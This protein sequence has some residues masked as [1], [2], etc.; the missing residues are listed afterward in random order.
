M[1]RIPSFQNRVALAA[2]LLLSLGAQSG[3]A[4][5]ETYKIDPTHSSIIFKIRHFFTPIPGRFPNF[6]GIIKLD[7][8][9][10]SNNYV[11]ATIKVAAIDTNDKKRDGHLQSEDFFQADK[12]PEIVYKSTRW[13][14]IEKNRY[15]VT[16]DLTMLDTTQSIVM[17]VRLNGSGD[18]GRGKFLTG[19][20]ASTS[21]DRTD[22]GI[23]YMQGILGTEVQI[24]ITVEAVK[25]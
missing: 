12:Y 6:A 7:R 5:I 24:E 1:K 20:E 16:G 2:F 25:Q 22:Y 9:D 23:S 17:D 13:E 18:N 21:L 4:E 3:F 15:R 11:E 19:W 14:S 10:A 8:E